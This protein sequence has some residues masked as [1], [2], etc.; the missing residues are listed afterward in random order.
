[1][2]LI[3]LENI[4]K[5]QKELDTKFELEFNYTPK[6]LVDQRT[7]ALIVELSE[8]A[9]EIAFF[10]YWK[11]NKNLNQD[12]INEEFVDG[13]H[14]FASLAIYYNLNSSLESKIVDK[15]LTIQFLNIYK[16]VGKFIEKKDSF[17]LKQAF[18][19]FLG[20]INLIGMNVK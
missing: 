19:L 17:Y 5:L 18:S 2:T 10:K 20:L 4:Y 9:N 15:D 7:L 12:K 16:N 14:F 13:I 6:E 1:M 11:K 8:L 3:N